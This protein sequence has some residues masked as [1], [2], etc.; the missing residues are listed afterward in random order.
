M[1]CYGC[2]CNETSTDPRGNREFQWDCVFIPKGYEETFAE[3]GKKKNEISMR[4]LAFDSFREFLV[5]EI[6]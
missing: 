3:M 1:G 6:L 2:Q 5:T 4:K